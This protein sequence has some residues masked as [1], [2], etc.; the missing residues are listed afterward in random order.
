MRHER[1]ALLRRGTPAARARGEGERRE[2]QVEQP[3]RPEQPPHLRPAGVPHRGADRRVDALH[4]VLGRRAARRGAPEVVP[5]RLAE[6]DAAQVG[7][8]L[9]RQRGRRRGR[10]S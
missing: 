1:G 6:A 9:C 7:Q 5:R 10:A 8:V 3:L 4:R 2:D